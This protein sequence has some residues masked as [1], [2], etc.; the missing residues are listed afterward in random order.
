MKRILII[1]F[2]LTTFCLYAATEDAGA[3]L[4]KLTKGLIF[5]LEFKPKL[6]QRLERVEQLSKLRKEV[7]NFINDKTKYDRSPDDQIKGQR[8]VK[9]VKELQKV[10]AEWEMFVTQDEAGLRNLS[11]ASARSKWEELDKLAPVTDTL[12]AELNTDELKVLL[13]YR[14]SDFKNLVS[15]GEKL[16]ESTALP[17]W[18]RELISRYI[19]EGIMQYNLTVKHSMS[20]IELE[21]VNSTNEYRMLLGLRA[22]EIDERLVQAA[23]KHSEETALLGLH[24]H[25]SPVKGRGTPQERCVLEGY[26]RYS[27][28]NFT[29]IASNGF[30]A[31]GVNKTKISSNE[32][33]ALF[34]LPNEHRCLIDTTHLQIGMGMSKSGKC[35]GYSNMWPCLN[36]WTQVFGSASALNEKANKPKRPRDR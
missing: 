32:A 35:P 11:P 29:G 5:S 33:G 30:E 28:E 34:Y 36:H 12:E 8:V 31:V 1:I 10:Y 16:L 6:K 19:S 9:L 24:G 14:T 25:E 7:L 26:D 23:R 27:N 2:Y 20:K 21:G 18:K 15:S 4:K 13:Y 22:L 17:E 3:E